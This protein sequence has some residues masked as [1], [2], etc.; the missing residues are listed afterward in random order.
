[1]RDAAS[2]VHARQHDLLVR[3][4]R[5]E[6]ERAPSA[7]LGAEHRPH[8]EIARDDLGVDGQRE[9]Q[10]NGVDLPGGGGEDVALRVDELD[11]RDGVAEGEAFAD[12]Q[13]AGD[14]QQAHASDPSARNRRKRS[15]LVTTKTEL[16]AIASP[17][18]IGSRKP[19]A[20]S[21]IAATLYAKAQNRLPLMVRSVARDSR[22]A[23]TAVARSPW[24]RVRSLAA[25]AT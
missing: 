5:N 14:G 9:L 11:G 10:R 8:E 7:R 17:A 3:L 18:I 1:M 6:F 13:G 15:E 23:S 12:G 4:G 19:R 20:A 24:T 25:I 16:N 21:G 22:T 2:A